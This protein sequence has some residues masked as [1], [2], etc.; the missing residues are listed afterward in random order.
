[1][2]QHEVRV[3]EVAC[4]GHGKCW[5][6]APDLFRW[7]DDAG[8]AEYFGGAILPASEPDRWRRADAAV[9]GCPEQAL[10]WIDDGVP[11]D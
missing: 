6:T 7:H 9:K 5:A 2:P 10:S 8:H 4:T 1:M 3:D 11:R